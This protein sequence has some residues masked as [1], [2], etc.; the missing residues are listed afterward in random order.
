VDV[1][2]DRQAAFEMVRR[3]RQ[4]G[5]PVIQVDDQFIIGFDRQRLE[6]AL[7][8]AAPR[9]PAFGAAVADAA[10]VA[11]REPGAPEAGAYVGRIH[12]PSPAQRAGIAAGDVIVAVNDVPIATAAELEAELRHL[13]PGEAVRVAF[14]RRGERL[15]GATR[16]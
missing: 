4:Q 9:R 13:Q 1:S 8:S 5:V 6:Q 10:S 16:L 3:T 14:L 11:S 7:T 15:A 12:S 2:K